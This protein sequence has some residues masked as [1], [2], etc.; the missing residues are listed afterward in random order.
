[1]VTAMTKFVNRISVLREQRG[2]HRTVI[3][4]EF[5]IGERTVRRWEDG[6]TPVPSTAIPKLAE[7]FDVTPEY[8]MGWDRDSET[9][10][11]AA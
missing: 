6:D 5:N 10:E 3:A 4:A 9:T 2:W 1:M 8:V 11:A 7:M